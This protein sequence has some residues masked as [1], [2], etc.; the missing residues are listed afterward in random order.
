MS[1]I[2]GLGQKLVNQVSY[3]LKGES[4]TEKEPSQGRSIQNFDT[5]TS[6]VQPMGYS[7]DEVDLKEDITSETVDDSDVV[8]DE[9]LA[10]DDLTVD[11]EDSTFDEVDPDVSSDELADVD[12]EDL[13]LEHNLS[14]TAPTRV[15]GYSSSLSE[16]DRAMLAAAYQGFEAL[17]LEGTSLFDYMD[18]VAGNSWFDME[19][20]NSQNNASAFDFSTFEELL[21]ALGTTTTEPESEAE[22]DLVDTLVDNL[23]DDGED[24]SSNDV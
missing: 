6:S 3:S 2:L 20:S 16:D 10:E 9:S 1:S 4:K 14:A 12:T 5:Y 15:H 18:D 17:K 23:T 8:L 19:V 21:A 22:S 7:N 24:L 11:G 13:D